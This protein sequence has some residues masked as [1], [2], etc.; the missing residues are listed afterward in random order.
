MSLADRDPGRRRVGL[1][2]SR[3]V[4]VTVTL[5]PAAGL[6]AGTTVLVASESVHTSLAAGTRKTVTRASGFA[7]SRTQS[8]SLQVSTSANQGIIIC[9]YSF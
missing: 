2:R 4:T 3:T 8:G 9:H 7:I 5:A 1:C 6:R